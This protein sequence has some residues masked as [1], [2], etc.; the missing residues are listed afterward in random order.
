MMVVLASLGPGKT[1]GELAL[2]RNKVSPG[3]QVR[4][5]ATIIA[6]TDTILAVIDKHDYG[7]VLDHIEEKN[8]D[9]IVQFFRQ[10]GFMNVLPY[11]M[12]RALHL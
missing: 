6:T 10:I 1:F 8:Q 11:R 12:V 5:A 9:G 7:I 2:L 3:K 4:R